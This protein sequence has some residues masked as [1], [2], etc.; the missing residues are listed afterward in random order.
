MVGCSWQLPEKLI[1][2]GRVDNKWMNFQTASVEF[3]MELC[4]WLKSGIGVGEKKKRHVSDQCCC[5]QTLLLSL[6]GSGMEQNSIGGMA[7]K[8][9]WS[10]IN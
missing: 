6:C 8:Y 3:A 9:C 7:L 1:C 4:S 2:S 5:S 10:D